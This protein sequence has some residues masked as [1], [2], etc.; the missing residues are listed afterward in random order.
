MGS[1]NHMMDDERSRLQ[2]R[3][4]AL[5]A[6][7]V[8]LKGEGEGGFRSLA[9]NLNVGVYRNMPGPEGRCVEANSTIADMFG[10]DSKQEFFA[11]RIIV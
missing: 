10:F 8:R 1:E 3:V 2:S 9:N 11:G 7:L 6:E 5:E 4:A